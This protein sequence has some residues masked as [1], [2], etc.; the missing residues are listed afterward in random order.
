MN[1]FKKIIFLFKRPPVIIIAGKDRVPTAKI[2][3]QFL[4]HQGLSFN[5][6]ESALSEEKDIKKL[7]FLFWRSRLPV[8]VITRL[9][10][11]RE[12]VRIRK[13]AEKLASRGFLILNF[14]DDQ[15]RA[16]SGN[17]GNCLTFGF[18][19]KADLQATDVY[20]NSGDVNFKI[21]Y[22]GNIVPFWL[23]NVFEKEEIYN[24]LAAVAMGIILNINLVE[25]SQA[26]R[27]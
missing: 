22:Q 6:F 21:D 24:I 17:L 27:K 4:K 2:I 1:L 14:D 7:S 13:L 3:S 25:I 9:E 16:L 26:L 12:S 18:Y 8:L 20:M 15:T 5:I 11:E 23:K 10:S 19:K